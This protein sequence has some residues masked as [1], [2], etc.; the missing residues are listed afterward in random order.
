MDDIFSMLLFEQ[1]GFG[2]KSSGDSR[3]NS[4]GIF[5]LIELYMANVETGII[6]RSTFPPKETVKVCQ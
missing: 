5:F 3:F 2:E 6:A 1:I 4:L